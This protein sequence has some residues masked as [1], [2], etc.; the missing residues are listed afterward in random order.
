[1]VEKWKAQ[2]I[3]QYLEE[4]LSNSLL[5]DDLFEAMENGYR[6]AINDIKKRYINED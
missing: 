2:E 1:M 5:N 4:Q 3:V 6:F